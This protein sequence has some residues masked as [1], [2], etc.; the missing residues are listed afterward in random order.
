VR[1]KRFHGQES[2]Q[3]RLLSARAILD[4]SQIKGVGITIADY[5]LIE[6]RIQFVW[7]FQS[8]A[9]DSSD[10]LVRLGEQG[11]KFFHK[12]IGLFKTNQPVMKRARIQFDEEPPGMPA[13]HNS[14][15][16]NLLLAPFAKI[17]ALD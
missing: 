17:K 4:D 14:Q 5:L 6:K 12:P 11:N 15:H 13:R 10:H 16:V 9:T 1:A 3:L 7:I 2:A 8:Q